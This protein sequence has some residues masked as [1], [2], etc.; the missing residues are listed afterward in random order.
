MLRQL[1][2]QVIRTDDERMYPHGEIGIIVIHDRK[3][4]DGIPADIRFQFLS[5]FPDQS[6]DRSLPGFQF[7]SG[8]FVPVRKVAVSRF[9]LAVQRT[10]PLLNTIPA[11]TSIIGFER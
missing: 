5:E 3:R 7:A 9:A 8:E 2:L 6:I 10:F 1:D 11:D 4:D